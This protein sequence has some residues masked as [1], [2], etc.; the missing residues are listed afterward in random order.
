M[1]KINVMPDVDGPRLAEPD[2]VEALQARVAL[3]EADLQELAYVASHDLTEP[4]RMITGY[5]ELLERR[6]APQLDETAGEFIAHAVDGAERMRGLLDDLLR[7][8]RAAGAEPERAP[9]DL[10]EVLDG[11]MRSLEPAIAETGSIVL[12]A[13]DLPTLQA[14]AGQLGQL[15]QNLIGNAVKFHRVGTPTRVLVSARRAHDDAAWL[16]EVSDDGIGIPAGQHERIF[17][18]FQRLQPREAYAGTG[19]GLAICRR[20]VDRLG[21]TLSV[22]S[23]PGEGSTFTARV[24]DLD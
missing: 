23:V 13:E 19:I 16:L 15:L 1:P 5:L 14:D 4:L 6:Y 7:Y 10:D 12:V 24:P 2:T 8:S 20:I 22:S 21:G 3:L 18:V 11:V 9:V 17:Q